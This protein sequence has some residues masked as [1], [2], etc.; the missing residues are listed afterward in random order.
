MVGDPYPFS[1]G[2][3]AILVEK[4]SGERLTI[5]DA[6]DKKMLLPHVYHYAAG[7]YTFQTLPDGSLAEGVLR[8]SPE[9][10]PS[11]GR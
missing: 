7:Q 11:P 1:V 6:V 5:Q 3:N 2:F 8:W 4:P 10:V 9:S